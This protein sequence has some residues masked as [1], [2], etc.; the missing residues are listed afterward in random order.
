MPD[1][2]Q[3]LSSPCIRRDDKKLLQLTPSLAYPRCTPGVP[4]VP[5]PKLLAVRGL[6][7]ELAPGGFS[8]LCAAHLRLGRIQ[9]G[10]G[11]GVVLKHQVRNKLLMAGKGLAHTG[12]G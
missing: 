7:R 10:E 3:R 5:P 2:T 1:P 9:K 11:G 6:R 12:T 8:S 4:G